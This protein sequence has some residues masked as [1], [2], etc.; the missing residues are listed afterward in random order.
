[1]SWRKKI[2]L[3]LEEASRQRKIHPKFKSLAKSLLEGEN[4][5]YMSYS[6]SREMYVNIIFKETITK[7]TGKIV[8]EVSNINILKSLIKNGRLY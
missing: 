1:M 3:Q 2:K 7:K 6:S 5:F 8:L 4:E